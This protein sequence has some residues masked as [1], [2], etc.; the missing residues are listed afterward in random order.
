LRLRRP[1]LKRLNRH[2]L[3]I[4]DAL[5]QDMFSEAERHAP[6]ETGGVLLGYRADRAKLVLV[7]DLVGAGPSARR[8]SHRF[9]PD[10]AWQRK[11]IADLYRSSGR[12][13]AYLGDWHSHPFD[14]D[15]SRLDRA[16]ARR[17]AKTPAARCPHPVMLIVVCSGGRWELR[18]YRYAWRR[19]RRIGVEICEDR[20]IR[21]LCRARGL[22]RVARAPATT[23]PPAR[24]GQSGP[25]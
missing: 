9:E 14:G 4:G 8:E 13:L 17:I 3:A 24:E 1:I 2:T 16:T 6:N 25:A 15:A 11:Q 22:V 19:L 18:A 7:S 20:A 21:E 23:R 12:T 5:A 10:G